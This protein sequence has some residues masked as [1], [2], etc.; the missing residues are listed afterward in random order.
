MNQVSLEACAATMDRKVRMKT[1][2]CDESKVILLY[3]DISIWTSIF[4]MTEESKSDFLKNRLGLRKS[5][6]RKSFYNYVEQEV[7]Q[8]IY[9]PTKKR[10]IETSQTI[11]PEV[12]AQLLDQD[13]I[14]PV[15]LESAEHSNMEFGASSRHRKE[16]DP[17]FL[18]HMGY[19]N[20]NARPP[21]SKRKEILVHLDTKKKAPVVNLEERRL[22][23]QA[24]VDQ[25]K[26]LLNKFS[27]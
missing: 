15:P 26:S 10:K 17:K 14:G 21:S 11:S 5:L 19:M 27:K 9:N 13:A 8:F 12:T 24:K 23:E 20:R 2:F 1:V 18:E 7:E 22:K 6:T 4:I 3:Y 25:M 16:L